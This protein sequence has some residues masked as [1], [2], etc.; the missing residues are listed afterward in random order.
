MGVLLCVGNNY[1][2]SLVFSLIRNRLCRNSFG[3]STLHVHL[4]L[5][6]GDFLTILETLFRV[7]RSERNA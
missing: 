3:M 4:I 7:Y 1:N 2:N 5:F 6:H